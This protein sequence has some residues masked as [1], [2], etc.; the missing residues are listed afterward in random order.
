MTS[1][2]SSSLTPVRQATLYIP[3][4]YLSNGR[5]VV[6][7]AT[8]EMQARYSDVSAAVARVH[9]HLCSLPR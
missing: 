6:E 1:T 7:C 9:R 3:M 8:C 4:I 5:Y 2:T